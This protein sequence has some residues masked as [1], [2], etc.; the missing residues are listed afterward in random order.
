MKVTRL[1]RDPGVSGWNALLPIAASAEVLEDAITAD[2]LVIGAGFA[3][4]AAA[5]RLAQLHPGDRIVMLEASRVGAGPAGRNSGFMIDLPHDLASEDYGGALE[6]DAAQ[7][8]AN[9]AGINFAAEMA[10]EYALGDEAFAPTGK[11]NGAASDAG[12][13][14]NLDYAAHL[15]A[16]NEAHEMLDA[17]Q[18]QEMTGS[19]YYCSGLLTPGTVMIHPAMFVRGVADGLRLSGVRIFESSPV[20]SLSRDGAWLATTPGGSISAPRAIL[21][22]NGH[23][24]S[25][26]HFAQQL[27]HVFTY[28]S[29][30]RALTS[31]ECATLGGDLRWGITPAHPLGTTVRRISGTGGDRIII[32][33]R[34]TMD[35]S[36]EVSGRRIARVGR[37]HD[38]AFVARFPML[39]DVSMQYRWGGRLCLSWNNVP[40][41]GEVDEGLFS[42]CCQNGLGTAKGTLHGML[43]ADLASG[44]HTPLLHDVMAQPAPRRLPPGPLTYLGANATMLW[45]EHKAGKEF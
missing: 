40:A 6:R 41:L 34:F 15:T 10:T 43:T 42:A 1:P 39:G 5:R 20:I 23:V 21:A 35:P 3:G 13:Q 8:R 25:F 16:M 45:G 33:N 31:E 27:L 4:L 11:V 32:R 44:H 26:G 14:N 28:A 9:R 24:N 29:M 19:S 7:T 30:T 36:M 37:D 22:V 18:M 38:R 2:W 12:H 17:S